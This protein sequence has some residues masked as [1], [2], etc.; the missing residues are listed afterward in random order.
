MAD[1]VDPATRSRMMSRIRGKDTAPEMLIRRGLHKLGYRYR[2]HVRKL[3]GKP[4]LVLP[5]FHAAIMVHGCF[6][7]GH[8]CRYFR[9]PATRRAFWREKI[10]A[11]RKRDLRAHRALAEHG[12]RVMTVWECALRDQKPAEQQRVVERIADW[13]ESDHRSGE[14]RDRGGTKTA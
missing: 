4:D 9:L 2:L 12:W 14:I 13:I 3:P 5:R 11:N 7:H 10:D 8:D 1:I 6:W